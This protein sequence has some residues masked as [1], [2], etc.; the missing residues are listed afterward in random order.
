MTEHI[1]PIMSVVEPLRPRAVL[2]EIHWL[3]ANDP[4]VRDD[5][6]MAV[7]TSSGVTTAWL[8]KSVRVING[9]IWLDCDRPQ[10]SGFGAPADEK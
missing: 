2:D 5:L 6:P 4:D 1:T 10:H 3:L 7:M 8:V 9:Q